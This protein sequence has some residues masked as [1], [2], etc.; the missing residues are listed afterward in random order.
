MHSDALAIALSSIGVRRIPI[1][2]VHLQ[3]RHVP[4]PLLDHLRDLRVGNLQP[5]LDRIAAAVEGALQ[6]GAVIGVAGDFSAPAMRLVNDGFQLLD[7]ERRL[8]YQRA[9][10]IEPGAMR[11]VDLDPVGALVQLFARSLAR[12]DGSVDELRSLGYGDL[13]RVALEGIAPG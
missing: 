4:R 13:R 8:R 12:F 9:L 3:G 6:S 10:R 5:M 7:G 11:H 1:T 2:V